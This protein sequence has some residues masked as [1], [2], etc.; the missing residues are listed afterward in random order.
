MKE[1]RKREVAEIRKKVRIGQRLNYEIIEYDKKNALIPVRRLIPV[2]VVKK[3]PYLVEVEPVKRW[4]GTQVWTM[5][6]TEIAMR[7]CSG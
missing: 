1:V 7:R 4:K 6:Y 3:Y 5:S 2:V